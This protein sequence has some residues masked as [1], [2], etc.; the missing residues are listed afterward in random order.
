V[1]F[2]DVLTHARSQSDVLQQ[3]APDE[4]AFRSLMES[5]F[6]NSDL[7]R[8]FEIMAQKDAVV[9]VTTDH[10]SVLC[11]RVSKAYGN[12]DTTTSLRFKVG[13]RVDGNPEESVRIDD[14][15]LYQ[16]PAEH[17][18]KNYLLAKEDY[19]FVYPTEFNA[20]KR[21]LKGGFQHGGISM[22]ELLVPCATLI[23]R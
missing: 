3:V 22:Q 14:P 18:G 11:D 9:V 4:R 12:R 1:N 6:K 20:Y 8:I 21:Q 13:E 19:Y 16:L 5:W 15:A 17:S 10:G 7:F 23:P 2:L